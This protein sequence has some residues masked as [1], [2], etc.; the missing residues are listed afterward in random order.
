MY[1][2]ECIKA[3]IVQ[4]VLEK[5]DIVIFLYKDDYKNY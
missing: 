3:E 4:E 2:K 1:A 5:N